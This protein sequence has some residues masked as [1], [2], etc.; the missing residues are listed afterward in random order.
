MP[1][2]SVGSQL[3]DWRQRRRLS[4]LDVA[5]DAEISQRHLSFIESGRAVPSRDMILRLADHLGVPLRERNS[6]V[7]AAGYAPVYRERALDDPELAPALRAVDAI[8]KGHEPY[9]A[10]AVD[11]LWRLLAANAAVTQLM[12]LVADTTLLQPPVNVLRVS[13]SPGGLA[14]V[15]VNLGQWRTHILDRLRVQ[16]ELTNDRALA[17]LRNELAALPGPPAEPPG[18]E[19]GRYGD[20]AVP[21]RLRTPAGDLEFITTTTVF[22]TPV[23]VTLSELALEMFFPTDE[24]TA[25]V[26]RRM[27]G[28]E[29][30]REV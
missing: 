30:G 25:R 21:L 22:G 26:L 10:L 27:A 16:V 28:G 2:R 5:L 4:Q 19:T 20:V 9:P 11:R 7:L 23:D 24:A 18:R 6:M 12:G 13:L 1:G 15:I 8:L 17:D 14:P 29:G 3:R